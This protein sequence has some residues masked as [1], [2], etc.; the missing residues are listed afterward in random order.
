MKQVHILTPNRLV[1]LHRTG[2]GLTAKYVAEQMEISPQYLCDIE[3]GRREIPW[4]MIGRFARSLGISPDE[5]VKAK[6]A[7]GMERLDPAVRDAVHVTVCLRS[8]GIAA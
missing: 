1:W 2:R 5:M 6:I 7:E 8:I 4:H 3:R